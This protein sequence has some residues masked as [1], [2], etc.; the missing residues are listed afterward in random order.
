MKTR[1]IAGIAL[2]SSLA[3]ALPARTA[4]AADDAKPAAA[5]AAGAAPSMPPGP[6]KPAPEMKQLDFFLGQWTCSGMSPETP[7]GPAH[8]TK[9]NVKVASDLDGFWMSGHVDEAKTKENSMPIHGVFH[10]TYDSSAKQ[11]TELWVDSFGGWSQQ[12]STGWNGD[13]LEM[14]GEAHGMGPAPTPTRDTFTKKGKNELQ[15][16]GSM[17]TDGKWTDVIAEDCVRA[18]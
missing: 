4:R 15:H 13:S 17:Q 12:S 14:T 9:A 7:W 3:L 6:P 16:V 5:P 18:H 11:F 2:C 10:W 1:T 8:S